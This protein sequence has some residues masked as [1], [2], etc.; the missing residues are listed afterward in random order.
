[1]QNRFAYLFIFICLFAFFFFS[2]SSFSLAFFSLILFFVFFLEMRYDFCRF[3]FCKWTA[4]IQLCSVSIIGKR[5]NDRWL[6]PLLNWAELRLRLVAR[7]L[8]DFWRSLCTDRAKP[9][10]RGTD[11]VAQSSLGSDTFGTTRFPERNSVEHNQR[12]WTQWRET[13][14][15]VIAYCSFTMG[16]ILVRFGDIQEKGFGGWWDWRFDLLRWWGRSFGLRGDIFVVDWTS[17]ETRSPSVILGNRPQSRPT[18]STNAN[19]H[20]ENTHSQIDRWLW[21]SYEISHSSDDATDKRHISRKRATH[22]KRKNKQ[23]ANILFELS[24]W[25]WKFKDSR[26]RRPSPGE[27]KRDLIDKPRWKSEQNAI[28]AALHNITKSFPSKKYFE[29]KFM[30]DFA[31]EWNQ[32]NGSHTKRVEKWR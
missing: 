22:G 25:E 14:V 19:Y 6:V 10:A 4:S 27:F 5:Y 12:L 7:F 20:N 8:C 11:N 29:I 30:I 3:S 1:M 16:V 32:S 2:S 31:S 28:P 9:I 24:L 13:S 23:R 18:E 21:N 26:L 17:H 15:E